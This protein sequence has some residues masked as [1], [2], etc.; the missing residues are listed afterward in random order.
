MTTPGD[1]RVELHQSKSN[2]LALPILI[3][4]CLVAVVIRQF[5]PSP[6]PTVLIV[7]GVGAVLDG[8]LSAYLLRNIGSTLVVTSDQIS[9]IK[10]NPAPPQVITRTPDSVLT[11]RMSANGP[12]GSKYTGYALKLRDTATGNEVYAGAFGQG[13]VRAACTSR[14]WTFS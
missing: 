3:A 13:R 10:K 11:F 5:F 4:V 14:G 7:C 6:S 1:A 2:V 9:F 8:L 12:V